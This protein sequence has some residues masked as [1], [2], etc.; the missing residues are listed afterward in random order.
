VF[1]LNAAGMIVLG[2]ANARLVPR[3]P[4]RTLLII[5]LVGSGIAAIAVLVIVGSPIGPVL[6][7]G[8]VLI[9]LF[10]VVATRGL[11]SANA[12]VLAVQRAPSAGAASAVL[13]ACMFGGGI[14][15][16]PLLA[17]GGAGS[18]VSMAAVVAGGALAALFA[19]VLLTRSPA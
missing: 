2:F 19:T 5:G 10:V 15:V 16:T 18:P 4:V 13:G 3:V 12:T 14:L 8:A 7:V 6:G 11:V 9:P 17:L 1:A